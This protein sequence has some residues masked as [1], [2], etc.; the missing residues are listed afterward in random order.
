MLVTLEKVSNEI[1]KSGQIQT[2][3]SVQFSTISEN[4]QENILGMSGLTE[5]L[6]QILS[7]VF[8]LFLIAACR[9]NL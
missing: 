1:E 5:N 9:L 8:E 7:L 2:K 6:V 4:L 3:A